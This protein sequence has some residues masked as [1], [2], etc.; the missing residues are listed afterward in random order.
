MLDSFAMYSPFQ[1]VAEGET[2]EALLTR[3]RVDDLAAQAPEQTI[4]ALERHAM[5]GWATGKG[6]ALSYLFTTENGS[7]ESHFPAAQS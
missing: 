3:A 5:D 4:L 1:K 6:A 2:D 7:L